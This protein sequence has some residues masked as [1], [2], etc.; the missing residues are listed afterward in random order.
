MVPRVTPRRSETGESLVEVLVAL[1]ILSIASVAILAGLQLSVQASDIHRKQ[2]TGGAYVRSY[3]EAI[4]SHLREDGNYVPCAP[5]NAYNVAAV[6]GHID[7]LPST[8]TPHQAAAVPLDGNGAQVGVAPCQD[9]GV[10]RLRLEIR[11]ADG[12]ATESLTIVVRQ[13]CGAGSSCS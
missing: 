12:R 1:S 2:T 6:T 13:T 7:T 8:F 11:S 3:A 9:K 5:A 4:E 10:Q